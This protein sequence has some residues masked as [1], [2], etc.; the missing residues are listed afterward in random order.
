METAI[1][2]EFDMGMS[3]S[4][5]GRDGG[6]HAMSQRFFNVMLCFWT[7]VGIASSAVAASVSLTWTLGWGLLLG[8]FAIAVIGILIAL[9][10]DEPI[11]SLLGYAMVTIPFGL[12]LGPLVGATATAVVIKAFFITT[13][14]VVVLGVMGALIPKSLESWA[15]YLF[16][17]LCLL[18]LGLLFVPLAAAFG[19]PVE[20]ALTWMDWAGIVLFG[21]YV[22]FDLNRAQRVQRTHDNAIDCALAVYLDFVNIFIRVLALSDD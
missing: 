13:A 12:M 11:I 5:W 9:R 3:K 22:I 7:A 2:E 15:P 21:F 17:G 6:T 16:G 20:G 10:S 18:I 19:L 4:V 1:W 14:M 8:T